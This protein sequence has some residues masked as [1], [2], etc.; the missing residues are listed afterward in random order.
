MAIRTILV[1][2]SH[3]SGTT[4]VGRVL[5]SLP[6]STYIHEPFNLDYPCAQYPL[7]MEHWFQRLD[8]G[9]G[10]HQQAFAEL[11]LQS[12]RRRGPRFVSDLRWKLARRRT[13]AIILKD[14]I[15]LLSANWLAE[16]CGVF[17][18]V[19]LRHPAAFVSSL[20]T[21]GWFFDFRNLLD[22]P[23]A[24]AT[25]FPEERETLA[26]VAGRQFTDIVY[27]ASVLWRLLHK[28][29]L[30]YRDRH[31]DWLFV[32]LEDIARDPL[33]EF[34]QLASQAGLPETWPSDEALRKAIR[35]AGTD[36]AVNAATERIPVWRSR[37]SPEEIKKVRQ[38]TE[39]T[40][41]RFYPDSEW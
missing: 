12:P 4:W 34:R 2:G 32:R 17:P 22:Q 40:A 3:R 9:D 25:F 16:R 39:T 5:A 15:A 6:G 35:Q 1:T 8:G 19:M 38:L 27:E 28:V 11:L 26:A 30:T 10:A 20:K 7:R 36:Q 33:R 23:D 41:A 21:H 18:L 13:R 29:I 24:I 14:P 37:L 31:P